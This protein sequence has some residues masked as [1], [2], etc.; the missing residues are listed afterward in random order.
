MPS[1]SSR[2]LE[3]N[4]EPRLELASWHKVAVLPSSEISSGTS[5]SSSSW[6]RQQSEPL[7]PSTSSLRQPTSSSCR[8]GEWARMPG[9]D[10]VPSRARAEP[11]ALRRRAEEPGGRFCSIENSIKNLMLFVLLFVLP[12]VFPFVSPSVLECLILPFVSPFVLY[13]VPPLK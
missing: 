3:R 5:K 4:L 11:R 9:S 1:P 8:A 13:P 10:L 12:S 6:R 2:R 7:L